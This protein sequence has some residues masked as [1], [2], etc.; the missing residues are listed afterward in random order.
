MNSMSA[1]TARAV[2]DLLNTASTSLSADNAEEQGSAGGTAAT[3]NT[4]G[5]ASGGKAP[6][7]RANAVALVI[8]TLATRSIL[9]L[10]LQLHT[11]ISMLY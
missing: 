9:H 8:T 7:T 5:R 6:S 2:F 11:C 1:K 10:V 4:A 3:S